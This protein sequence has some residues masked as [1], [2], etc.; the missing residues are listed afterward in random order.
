[1]SFGLYL[2]FPFCFSK[3]NY[4]NFYSSGDYNAVPDEYILAILRELEIHKAYNPK[5]VY[6]GGGTPSLLSVHQVE[7]LLKAISPQVNA[8]ITLEVNPGTVSIDQLKGYKSAGVNRLSIG[9]QSAFNSQLKTLGRIHTAEDAIKC[10][11]LAQEAGFK[12]IS[13]DIML[14][15]PS[16]SNKEFD[17]TITL[18]EQGNATHI[19]CY[20]LKVEDNTPF[21]NMNLPLPS[22]DETADFYL[23]AVNHLAKKGYMQYE[24]SNFAKPGFESKHNLV[25]WN[26]ENY[27]GIGP[28]AHSCMNGKRFHYVENT[29]AFISED[30]NLIIQDSIFTTE[31]YIMLQLRLNKGLSL[32][33]LESLYGFVFSEKSI[34]KLSLF[35]KEGLCTIQNNIVRLTTEGMLIQNYVLGEII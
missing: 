10:F 4:C 27:L 35:E 14:A 9:V 22:E 15:L 30:R 13:G 7:T 31:E 33:L 19:S 18:I 23:Y 25:Y 21:Y 5:T 3:C 34:N 2:H 8:E 26:C 28:A 20:L 16:Y 17:E 12:N 11:S 1:M 6:F 32:T 24:I 29:D